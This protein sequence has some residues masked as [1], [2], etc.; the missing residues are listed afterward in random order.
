MLTFL[1]AVLQACEWT[2]SYL[3]YFTNET[4]ESFGEEDGGGRGSGLRDVIRIII[5]FTVP[6]TETRSISP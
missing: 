2:T 3:C 5:V 1:T 4:E 6:R